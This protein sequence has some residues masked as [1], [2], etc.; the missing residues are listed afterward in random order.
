NMWSRA[1]NFQR[2]DFFNPSYRAAIANVVNQ[3]WLKNSWAGAYNDDVF[4]L[5]GINVVG[6]G[7]TI[8][9]GYLVN[10]PVFKEIYQDAFLDAVQEIKSESGSPWVAANTSADNIFDRRKNRMKYIDVFDSFLREDYIRPGL[11]LDGYFGI[12]KMWDTFALAQSN[13]KT[14]VIVHAGWRDPIPMVNTKDA[15]ESRI[16]T[17]LAMYYLINVPGKTSYTSWNSSYNYGSGNTVEANFYKAGVP[18]NI[19]YQP[20]FMLAVDIGKP[21]QNIQEWPEQ[22]IQ[23]LIYTAKTTGDDYTVIGDSTQSV[24]THPGIATFDQM[25][26]VPVIPSNIYY[27]WQAEDKI[28]IGGVDFPKKM[29][30]ARDYTNGL[31]LYQTDFFGANPGFMSITNELTLPGYYH[32]VNYDGTLETATNK[33]SLTGYE[34]VVLV[35]SK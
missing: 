29:I 12:A 7:K 24:L 27:A 14:A 26:T 25:G 3:G 32:R 22:T 17:G 21:A 28:V 2:P 10:D 13:K 30:I 16:S 34:G 5:D 11:G 23:P 9:Y 19:A 8:E 20:S 18:K 1:S 6:G 35:K 31:V 33:V 4:K 15:W